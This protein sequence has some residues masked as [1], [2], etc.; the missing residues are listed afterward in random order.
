MSQ[1]L[2]WEQYTW[3][4][5]LDRLLAGNSTQMVLEPNAARRV[6]A[7]AVASGRLFNKTGSTGGFGAYAAFVPELKLGLVMVANRNFPVTARVTAA[8]RVLSALT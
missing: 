6:D 3:A 4:T 8:H 1:G 2:G 5:D 7:P